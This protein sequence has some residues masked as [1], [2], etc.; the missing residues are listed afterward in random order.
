MDRIDHGNS[1]RENIGDDAEK[2]TL[3]QL[4]AGD[5]TFASVTIYSKFDRQTKQ[6]VLFSDVSTIGAHVF[7]NFPAK[8]MYSRKPADYR[9]HVNLLLK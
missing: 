4:T 1:T 8:C 6:T 3:L 2:V 9:P 5:R 7:R